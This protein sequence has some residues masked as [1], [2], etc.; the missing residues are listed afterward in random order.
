M[1][2]KIVNVGTVA[3]DGTGDKL[4]NAFIKINDNFD[5]VYEEVEGNIIEIDQAIDRADTATQE[6]KTATT[7]ANNAA[8]TANNAKGWSPVLVLETYTLAGVNRSVQKLS[9]YIGGTGDKPT[10]NVGLYLKGDGTFGTDRDLASNLKGSDGIEL[11]ELNNKTAGNILRA[12]GV[13][14]R[15]ISE[16]EFLKSKSPFL[17]SPL[18]TDINIDKLIYWDNFIRPNSASL[19]VADSGQAYQVLNGSG[20][21]IL[22]NEAQGNEFS[23]TAIPLPKNVG[24]TNAF[25]SKTLM[26]NSPPNFNRREGF[27]YLIDKDN[28]I[29][30]MTNRNAIFVN[31]KTLG[32][33]TI[34]AS[35]NYEIGGRSGVDYLNSQFDFTFRIYSDSAKTLVFIRSEFLNLNTVIDLNDT[36]YNNNIN[37][38]GF[39]ANESNTGNIISSKLIKDI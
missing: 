22:D 5:E 14:F 4:R 33:D 37:Y 11:A 1:I 36:S 15:S 17:K 34:L 38:F 8:D 9:D 2:K 23:I 18:S 39:I 24:L 7:N 32:V 21:R 28:S 13:K 29:S 12:D 10:D 6:A 26:R 35:Y 16:V 20:W 3:N 30:L 19:G 31:K 25:I 27:G